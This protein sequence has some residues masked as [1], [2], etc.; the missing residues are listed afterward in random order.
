MHMKRYN[1]LLLP[2][3]LLF[4]GIAG[5]KTTPPKVEEG[6]LPAEYFKKA[7]EA[8]IDRGN[9]VEA[10]AYYQAVLDTYPNDRQNGII[11]KYEIAFTHYKQG[12]FELAKEE[13]QAILKVYEEDS[14]GTLPP[15]PP[16]LAEKII[17][18][19]DEKS[20]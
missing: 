17:I 2:I 18:K 10:L 1:A 13:F 14:G 5:C 15:W 6:L 20:K 7:Q 12:E 3:L 19:I 11:A 16:V 9:Y 4:I 8:V